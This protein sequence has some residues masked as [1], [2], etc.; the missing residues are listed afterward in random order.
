M[1][2]YYIDMHSHILPGVDDGAPDMD[3][4]MKLVSEAYK[5][6]VRR[7]IATPHYYPG[8]MKYPIE[9]LEKVYQETQSVI[10]EKY[11]DF[12]L[13]SGN[14]IYYRDEVVEKLNH[15]RIFT[16]ANTRYI[17]LEFSPGAEYGYI[18]GAVRKCIED[19]Y[20]P[21]LA[22][23]ERYDCLWRDTDNIAALIRMGAYMQM[24]AENFQGGLFSA[25]K[26]C[27]KLIQHG[28]IHFLGS[29]CHNMQERRPNLEPAFTYL[30]P[31]LSPEQFRQLAIENPAKLLDNQYL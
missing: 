6:G 9:H 27:L 23:T 31:R 30:K 8:H 18:T 20:Y 19:G 26:R 29:D 13:Y 16:L 22:H 4:T 15:K 17:L 3:T 21:V 10:K 1:T 2:E 5:Q 11:S 28:M 12:T 7:M 25:R 14:E 24:N